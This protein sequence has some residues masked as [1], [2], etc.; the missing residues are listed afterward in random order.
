VHAIDPLP[1]FQ[2]EDPQPSCMH[3][4]ETLERKRELKKN[5]KWPKP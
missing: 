3:L 1:L 4:S 5:H 2:K